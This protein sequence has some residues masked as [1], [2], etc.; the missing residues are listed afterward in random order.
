MASRYRHG[1]PPSKASTSR[2]RVPSFSS[3]S[4]SQPEDTPRKRSKVQSPKLIP[5]SVDSDSDERTP[6]ASDAS[7]IPS[8]GSK[9]RALSPP[10]E[11]VFHKKR[12]HEFAETTDFQLIGET[13]PVEYSDSEDEQSVPVRILTDFTIYDNS[14][15]RLVPIAE[16]LQLQLT[17]RSYNASGCVKAWIDDEEWVDDDD[18]DDEDDDQ[19]SS[20]QLR[21]DRVQRL[22]L[23]RIKRF[24]IHDM[25]K[26]GRQLDSNIYILTQHAWYILD[27]P[28]SHYKPFYTGFWLKHRILHLLVSSAMSQPRL[29]YQD[30][31]KSL[32]IT[33]ESP[34]DIRI[35]QRMIGRSITEGDL[36]SDDVKPYLLVTLDELRE[37]EQIN[38]RRTPVMR[39]LFG[40]DT[41]YEDQEGLKPHSKPKSGTRGR[42]SQARPSGNV[43]LQVLEHRN[44]TVVTAVV[45]RVAHLLFAQNIKVAGKLAAEDIDMDEPDHAQVNHASIVHLANPASVKWGRPADHP[46]YYQSVLVDGVVYSVGD[47]VMVEPG[48]DENKARAKSYCHEPSQSTNSLANSHWFCRIRYLFQDERG[49]KKFHGQWLTHSSKSLLQELGHSQALYLMLTDCA[50]IDIDAISQKC[51]VQE[52]DP[53]APEP[54]EADVTKE[55]DFF[56]RLMF[57]SADASLVSLSA[58]Q[59]MRA[60]A[61]CEPHQQCL[62]CGLQVMQSS[63]AHARPLPGGGFAQYEFSYHV[64]DFVYIKRKEPHTVYKIGQIV[65]V[66]GMRVPI[67]VTVQL[68]GR[69]DDVVRRM[70]KKDEHKLLRF[71]DRR[72]FKTDEAE[73]VY[74]EDLQGICYVL[75]KRDTAIIDEWVQHDDHYYVNQQASSLN[76][77]S[78]D[79]LDDWPKNEYRCCTKCRQEREELLERQRRLLERHGRL[80]GLELFSGAGGLGTGFDLSGFVET[81]WAIEFSPSAARTYQ[82]NHPGT[83][84]YNQCTNLCL[85]HAIDTLE[86]KHPKPLLSLDNKKPLPPMPK[87]GDVDFIYGGP[88]CQSFSLM[89]HNKKEFDIRSTLVCNMLSYVEFYRPMYLLLENVFGILVHHQKTSSKKNGIQ[90]AVVKLIQ[91]VLASIGYQCQFTVLQAAQY[92]APQ[93]RKRVIFWGARRD[94]LMPEWPIPTH[95]S[96]TKLCRARL[97]TGSTLRPNIRNKCEDGLDDDRSAPLH[98]VTIHEAIGDLPPFDWTNPHITIKAT[99]DDKKEAQK[100]KNILMIPTFCPLEASKPPYAGFSQP[101]KHISEPLSRYQAWMRQRP[102]GVINQ[103]LGYHYTR[104]WRSNVAE[105]VCAVP[106]KAGANQFSL[107]AKLRMELT[108]R[109]DAEKKYQSLYKRLDANH[110]FATALTTLA[111]NTKGGAVLHPSQKRILSVQECARAQGFPDH[112]EFLSVNDAPNKVVADQLRQIGNAVPVPLAYALGKSLGQAL[113][114]LWDEKDREGSP[115]V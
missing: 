79:D 108:N 21:E 64:H 58:E 57:N 17:R 87:Q 16:L 68:F 1:P 33:P 47:T 113:L 110:V 61:H 66:K 15:N 106:L 83:I 103:D 74:D 69:Y 96:P 97:P 11:P 112:Y 27:M 70:R 89:N 85:H 8:Y 22:K 90:V 91:R 56:T 82:R 105:R 51:N 109:K 98:F 55:N 81:R 88:P 23:T 43:E 42:P 26:R 41:S 76:V 59:T 75:H 31:V 24:A 29:T 93:G 44:P 94:V 7:P 104:R 37:D 48:V 115:E 2:K 4:D 50:D 77:K 99:S 20:S 12:E 19:V 80:R 71:D 101:R 35:A 72:L 62:S 65:K 92:G 36:Q 60:L 28:S 84:V 6:I 54:I 30:F 53:D 73:T 114:K 18:T 38:I 5:N 3:I 86:N 9:P 78:I 39:T 95:C 40:Q 14:T 100:R 34:E 49:N 13:D 45:G 67:E 10:Q 107:P 46:G 52:L 111:P 102:D 25:K 63:A 32:K